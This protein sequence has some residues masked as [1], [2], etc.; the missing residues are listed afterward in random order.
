[1]RYLIIPAKDDTV[2]DFLAIF[3]HRLDTKEAF[4]VELIGAA[5]R[6]LAQ[7]GLFHVW[8][9]DVAAYFYNIP[10]RQVRKNVEQEAIKISLKRMCYNQTGWSFILTKKV[11]ALTNEKAVVLQSTAEYQ[12]GEMFMFMDWVQSYVANEPRFGNTILECLGEYK[13]LLDRQ[14][15]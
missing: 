10:K 7:N 6:S 9:T 15:T 5:Q 12:R 3:E 11:D 14:I 8:C 1:M 4:T 13:M 2:Q